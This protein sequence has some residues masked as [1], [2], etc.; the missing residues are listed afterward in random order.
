MWPTPLQTG[1]FLWAVEQQLWF[2]T[3]LFLF[4][5]FVHMHFCYSL[6]VC[7]NTNFS[8]VCMIVTLLLALELIV[9]VCDNRSDFLGSQDSIHSPFSNSF[10]C[11]DAPT[12]TTLPP[13]FC[14]RP[15]AF[16]TSLPH[17]STG[18]TYR[19]PQA[20]RIPFLRST[21]DISY[22]WNRHLRSSSAQCSV[23]S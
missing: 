3:A 4:F 13:L 10:T 14:H 19:S 1:F 5:C 20:L 11:R 9:P 22:F 21:A 18:S 16:L 17:N 8:V 2:A 23:I 15:L 6:S 12:K 7:S